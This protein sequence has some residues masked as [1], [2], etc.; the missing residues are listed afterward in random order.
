MF[1]CSHFLS[2]EKPNTMSK[3]AQER[4]TGEELVVAKSKP[5]SLASR[6]LSVKQ[7]PTLNSGASYKPGNPRL[8]R[9]SVFTSTGRP[10]REISQRASF[11][12]PVCGIKNQLTRMKLDHLNL[13]ISDDLHIE[14]VF[15]KVRQ[16]LNRSDWRQWMQAKLRSRERRIEKITSGFFKTNSSL[17]QEVCDLEPFIS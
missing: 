7:S 12:K 11:G 15:T 16:R 14:K 4:R 17:C 2:I 9:N 13:Q 6:K 8:G 1:S 3:W 5:I 10:V